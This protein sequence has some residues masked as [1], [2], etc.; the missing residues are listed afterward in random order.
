MQ[1][2][3]PMQM[4]ILPQVSFSQAIKLAFKIMQTVVDVPEEVNFGFFIFLLM[5]RISF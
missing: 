3:M 1:M 5:V 4:Q 2:P